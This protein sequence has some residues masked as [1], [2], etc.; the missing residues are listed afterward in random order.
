MS[1]P[2][3]S[4]VTVRFS[5]PRYFAVITLFSAVQKTIAAYYGSRGLGH[6]R[7]I[8]RLAISY[9][10]DERHPSFN[11]RSHPAPSPNPKCNL[12][13]QFNGVNAPNEAAKEAFPPF[14]LNDV[15]GLFERS[16]FMKSPAGRFGGSSTLCTCSLT[17]AWISDRL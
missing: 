1:S 9:D 8:N 16:L 3:H 15:H 6:P 2:L 17:T 12:D 11:T 4:E 13:L 14:P 7:K 5:H 10:S